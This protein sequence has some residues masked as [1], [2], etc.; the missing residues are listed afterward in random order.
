MSSAPNEAQA[1]AIGIDAGAV[2]ITEVVSWADTQIAK[3]SFPE[4]NLIELALAKRAPEALGYLHE[5]AA[6]ADSKAVT[7]LALGRRNSTR[8]NRPGA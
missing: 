3:I 2:T 1:L 8:T 5:L 6:G 7:Q 4:S